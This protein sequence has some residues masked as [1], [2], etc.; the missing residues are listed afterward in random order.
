[1][2]ADNPGWAA[3]RHN[4]DECLSGY[5]DALF[6]LSRCEGTATGGMYHAELDRCKGYDCDKALDALGFAPDDLAPGDAR[7]IEEDLQGFVTSCLAER[8]D[9]FDGISP[10]QVGH[11]FYLT[12]NRH[13]AGFWDRGLGERGDWLTKMSRPFG[14]QVAYVH[15]GVVYVHG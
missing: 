15:S 11:D 5:L 1:M 2:S 4:W 14:T 12:R 7:E 6:W 8:P 13:G 3:W 9:V 10:G